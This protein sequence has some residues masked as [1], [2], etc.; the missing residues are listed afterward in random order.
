MFLSNKAMQRF[1]LS[2]NLTLENLGELIRGERHRR[3]VTLDVLEKFTG[4]TKKTMIKIEKG[5]DAKLST[6]L[7]IMTALDLRL[8]LTDKNCI[9]Q[10]G[11]RVA[12]EDE[13]Y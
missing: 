11:K 12:I 13:W 2:E 8:Q 10:D 7:K 9:D 5:G 1:V 6:I 3:G 4:I